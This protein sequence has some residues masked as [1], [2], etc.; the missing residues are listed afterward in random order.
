MAYDSIKDFLFRLEKKGELITI[1]EEVDPKFEV[2]GI[3]KLLGENENPA[4]LFNKVKGYDIPIVGNLFGNKKRLALTLEVKEDDLW[5]EYQKRLRNPIPPVL[6]KDGPVQEVIVSED[7]DILKT[8]P[9]PTYHDRDISPYITQGIVFLRDPDTGRTTMGVHRIQVK[10]KNKLGYYCEAGSATSRKF[11]ENAQRKGQSLPAAI[12][13]GV[14]PAILLAA[15]SPIPIPVY[16]KLEIAGGLQGK[17]VEVVKAKTIEIEVPANAMFVIEGEISPGVKEVDGPFGESLGF[18]TTVLTN[19][20]D[21]KLITH[22]KNPVYSAFEPFPLELG[23]V[24]LIEMQIKGI[25]KG[26]VPCMKDLSFDIN[27]GLLV[28]SI[29]KKNAWE[30]KQALYAGLT[31]FPLIKYAIVVNEDIDVHNLKEVGWALAGRCQPDEDVIIVNDLLASELDPS[32]KEGILTSKLGLDA[33]YP[34]DKQESFMKVSVPKVSMEKAAQ[35]L[36]KYLA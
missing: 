8:M 11:M 5:E 26:M 17:P 18:Y 16:N 9:V 21:V 33:T 22:Q 19:V 20:I 1:E 36:K 24:K 35:I 28:I 4:V 29:E 34:L 30:S 10:G 31:V 15:I 3:L 23:V 32:H 2:S 6:V 27:K 13:I 25:L 14:S 12:A 7:V